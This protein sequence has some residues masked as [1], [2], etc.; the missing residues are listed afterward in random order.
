MKDYY[1]EPLPNLEGVRCP[2]CGASVAAD[3]GADLVVHEGAV[4]HW[5][6]RQEEIEREGRGR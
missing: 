6:C 4:Y 5:S 3:Q 1:D 2:E